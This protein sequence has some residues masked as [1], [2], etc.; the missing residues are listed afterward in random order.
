VPPN[1][2]NN[3]VRYAQLETAL[4]TNVARP[5][6]L[7]GKQLDQLIFNNYDAILKTR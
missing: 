3:P 4:V 2:F 6:K 5:L 1:A 7:S